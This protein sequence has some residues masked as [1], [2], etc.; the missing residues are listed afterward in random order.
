M[1]IDIP[2]QLELAPSASVDMS[3]RRQPR[4]GRFLEEFEPGTI[5]RHPRG[6]TIP[7]DLALS[8]ATTFMQ[9]NP[10]YLNEPF[11]RSY[12]FAGLLVSPLMVLN[13]ALSLG[14]QNDSEQAIA[15]L[16]YYDVQFVKP[17]YA[18]DTLSS[19]TAVIS[20]RLRG[21]D[22]QGRWRPGVVR[23]RTS[24]FNQRNELV[25]RYQRAI[26]VPVAEPAQLS[27]SEPAENLLE[28][29]SPLLSIELPRPTSHPDPSLTGAHTYFEDYT[30]GEILLHANGRTITEEHI[31]W[32]YR[33]GN[34]HPLHSDRVYSQARSGP[35]SGEP[36]VYGGLVFAWLEGL[37]SRDTSENALWDLGYTEGYHTQPATAGDTLYAISRVLAKTAIQ[38]TTNAG[39]VTLQ[40]IGVKNRTGAAALDKHGPALFLKESTKARTAR[41]P[42]KLFEIERRLLIKK[43]DRA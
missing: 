4:Y 14:V 2:P 34:T 28:G 17:V 9:T 18:G 37:A 7:A 12:G 24:A 16:G 23:I 22:A 6:L 1:G 10:L 20:R 42:E 38:G 33:L 36:I 15:H 8:F 39:I 31:P 3:A 27:E 35:M 30:I 25:V 29:D 41:I 21:R 40:L 26:L 13:V 11:A 5:F 32:T 43:R 19:Q